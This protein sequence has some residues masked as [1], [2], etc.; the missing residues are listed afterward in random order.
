VTVPARAAQANIIEA[1]EILHRLGLSIETSQDIC[2]WSLEVP[3]VSLNPKAGTRVHRGATIEIIPRSGP[4]GSPDVVA[5]A[6]VRV[7][8]FIG[9]G[10]VQAVTWAD[11]HNIY[12][13]T[14]RLP[15]L[16]SATESSLFGAYQVVNERPSPGSLIGEGVAAGN[17][18][19]AT[20]LVLQVVVRQN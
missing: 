12:W 7:P 6:K 4:L 1:Y 18:F 14:P 13:A 16:H 15:I 8:N 9:G 11:R 2:M 5:E 10:L 20:P 19:S 17:T 3:S